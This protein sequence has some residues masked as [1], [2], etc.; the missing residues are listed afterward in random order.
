MLHQSLMVLFKFQIHNFFSSGWSA[1]SWSDVLPFYDYFDPQ[2]GKEEERNTSSKFFTNPAAKLCSSHCSMNIVSSS[3]TSKF[4]PSAFNQFFPKRDRPTK[5][6]YCSNTLSW[7]RNG[8]R[9]I[10]SISYGP[11]SAPQNETLV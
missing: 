5:N 9:C 11:K 6:L 3:K 2:M 8:A 7:S 10:S 1:A 4:G